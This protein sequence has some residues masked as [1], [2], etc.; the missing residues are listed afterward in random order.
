MTIMPWCVDESLG[1]SVGDVVKA[2]E[3][4]RPGE[5]EQPF[6]TSDV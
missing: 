2:I 5:P 3:A 1:D 6:R 4:E